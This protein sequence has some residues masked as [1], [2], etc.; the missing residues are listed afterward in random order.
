MIAT[1]CVGLGG[2]DEGDVGSKQGKR[3]RAGSRYIKA[4]D[5]LGAARRRLAP[6]G[7]NPLPPPVHQTSPSHLLFQTP[8]PPNPL[9]SKEIASYK[10]LKEKYRSL[11]HPVTWDPSGVERGCAGLWGSFFIFC[12]KEVT[13]G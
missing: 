5:C 6:R 1:L 10:Q 3:R 11:Y 13:L 2:G 4:I 9:S 8:N 12:K 7:V